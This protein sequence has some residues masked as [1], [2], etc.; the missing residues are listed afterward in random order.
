MEK[1]TFKIT[2][3]HCINALRETDTFTRS[4]RV[5]RLVALPCSGMISEVYLLKAFESGADAV[6]LL[7]CPEDACRHMEGSSRAAKR[8][9]RTQQTLDTIGLGGSRLSIH[10]LTARDSETVNGILD[11]ITET[12]TNPVA[13]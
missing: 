12:L 13:A 11:A 3:F 6:A 2:M 7:V 4:D 9:K 5:V 10:T 8:I 1:N